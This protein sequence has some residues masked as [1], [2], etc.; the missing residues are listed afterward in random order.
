MFIALSCVGFLA[1][2][3]ARA[4]V[5]ADADDSGD[6]EPI[7]VTGTREKEVASVKSVAPIK[8][9]PRSIV[10]I[11]DQQIRET[12]SAT[13]V[14]ALRTVPGITFG[15]AEGGNPIGDQPFIRGFDSQGSTFVDG[16]RDIGAQSREV[17]AVDQIQ[18]VR[19][20][21]STL[22]GRGS[23]GGSINIV[24]RLPRMGN[25]VSGE[26]SLGTD[27]Y[28]RLTADVNVEL[29]AHAAVRLDAMWHDQDVARRDA[30][31]QRRWGLAPSIAVGLGTP[32]RL[33]ASFYHLHTR[34]LPD[35][36]IP[37]LYTIANAPPGF[38]LDEPAR[39]FTTIGGAT[40]KVGHDAFY[41]IKDR[42]FRR[43]DTDQAMVRIE[44]DLS[45]TVTVRNT[46]RY[47]RSSQ[48]YIYTQPDDQ[49]GNVFGTNPANPATAGGLVWRRANSR[50][51]ATRSFIDQ[52][53]AYGNLDTGGIEHSFAAGLEYSSERARRGTFLLASGSTLSPRCQPIAIARFYCT[54]VFDPNP[55][56]PFVNYASDTSPATAPIVRGASATTTISSAQTKAAYAFDS[57][58]LDPKLI[59][60]LGL[61]YDDYRTKVRLP[62]ANGVRPTVTRSDG[63]LNYQ[64]GLVFKPV[65]DVSLYGSIATASTP[66]GSL[67]G[68]GREG[69]ALGSTQEAADALRV[70][71][72]RSY[73]VG[74]KA[75]LFHDAML[76][77]AALFDTTTSNARVTGEDNLA[78]FIGKRRARGFELGVGGS[79]TSN[80]RVNGGYTYLDA[81]ITDGGFTAL[82]A[83]AV[84][85]QAAKTVLVPS[86]NTGKPFPQTAK[87]SATL[88]TSYDVTPRLTV[89]GGVVYNSRVYGNFSDNRAA[90]QDPN[91]VVTVL[92]ATKVIARS[93]P[94]Y[95]RLDLNARY[96]FDEHFE[97]RLNVQNLTDAFY[98]DKVYTNHYATPAPGRS[99]FVT[100]AVKY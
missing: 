17:F 92:P 74:A 87:H 1:S 6:R 79:I 65:P 75:S 19:G 63:L 26:A 83:P 45:G 7:V 68:E 76:L 85:G 100:L 86:V 47:T 71:K 22:G 50:F 89:G 15:A 18:I 3:P 62:V 10:V 30:L 4:A 80:W 33:T 36:G 28:K 69:N 60:N 34:E 29:A 40:G 52:A 77:T 23:A 8:D 78:A 25:H 72:T 56:A 38:T 66:P 53:D 42:D 64:A 61:R 37:Y 67:L 9:T 14:E 82:T 35:S 54:S 98:Y 43:T 41:G 32:T 93:V 48:A 44:R 2:F 5:A 31:F 12:G 57:I 99:G 21:D 59:L 13:L 11:D 81:R 51:E 94:G 70:E 90:V 55:D 46:A 20:S 91:G 84:P 95:V 24:S 88:F 49:Q 16:V 27:D 73:E 97:V 96:R 58:T 39:A